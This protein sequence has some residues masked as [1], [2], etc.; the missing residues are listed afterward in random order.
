VSIAKPTV[1]IVLATPL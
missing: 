1:T